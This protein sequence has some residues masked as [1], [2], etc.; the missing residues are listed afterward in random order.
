MK[1]TTN[2][3]PVHIFSHLKCGTPQLL[4]SYHGPSASLNA[5]I[6]QLVSF[7]LGRFTFVPYSLLVIWLLWI[8]VGLSESKDI[9][10][11]AHHN[12]RV[13]TVKLCENQVSFSFHGNELLCADLSH[14]I[15]MKNIEVCDSKVAK[16]EGSQ[17][18]SIILQDNINPT[19]Q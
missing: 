7:G 2:S 15:H 6:S 13:L 8:F 19:P 18:I 14:K 16:F 1:Y 12:F 4:Q 3:C 9:N 11:N 10:T 5:L 17:R